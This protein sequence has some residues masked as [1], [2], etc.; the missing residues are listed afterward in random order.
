MARSGR[1]GSRS[2]ARKEPPLQTIR[3]T[4]TQR[5]EPDWDAWRRERIIA[6][7]DDEGVTDAYKLLR[8]RVMQRLGQNQW[9]TLGITSALAEEGKT[10]TAINLA[11]SIAQKYDHTVLLVDADLRR[12]S[13]HQ[14]LGFEPRAGIIECLRGEAELPDVLVNTGVER[15]VVLPG[16][17]G[18]RASSELLSSPQMLDLVRE[19]KQRYP[20]RIVLFDLPPVLVGDDA[21]AFAPHLESILLV[22]QDGRTKRQQLSRALELLEQTPIVGT[23]LNRSSAEGHGYDYY[24]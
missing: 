15:F 10:L 14:K 22:I 5:H 20:S 11:L 13:I 3:Y 19:L 2:I 23:V 16:R 12:P 6:A 9:N 8:T 24:Y 18:T 1:G 4:R 7:L 17:S 21:V